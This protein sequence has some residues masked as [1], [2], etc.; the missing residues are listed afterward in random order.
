MFKEYKSKEIIRKAYEIKPEDVIRQGLGD[1]V[2]W[3]VLSKEHGE[4]VEFVAHQEVVAGDFIV[5]LNDE[6]VYHCSR[7]VFFER[8]IV[9][10]D[11][12]G[13]PVR[14]TEIEQMMVDLNCKGAYVS[15]AFIHERIEEVD[16]KTIEL[17]GAKLMFCGI[18]MKGGFVVVGEPSACIDPSNWREEI[19]KKVSFENSFDKIYALEAYRKMGVE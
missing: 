9:A 16:F 12:G 2:I 10:P 6:D 11:H 17:A 5:F 1:A 4:T 13:E 14:R 8:N 15:S 3:R 19:G 18:R 7:E